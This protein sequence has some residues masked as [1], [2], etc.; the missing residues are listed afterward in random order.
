MSCASPFW[1]AI[2]EGPEEPEAKGEAMI[3]RGRGCEDCRDNR[4]R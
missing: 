2:Q 3:A 4:T 1:V